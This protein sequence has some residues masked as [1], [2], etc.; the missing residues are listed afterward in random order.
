[1]GWGHADHWPEAARAVAEAARDREISWVAGQ[2]NGTTLDE[3]ELDA[4]QAGLGALPPTSSILP[5][6]GESLSSAMLRLLAAVFALERQQ[7]PA[8]PGLSDPL[9]QFAAQ[10]VREIRPA[11]VHRVLVASFGAGRRQLRHRRRA[12]LIFAPARSPAGRQATCNL[13]TRLLLI[14]PPPDS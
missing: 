7:L 9:R 2:G 1:M 10:L 14:R 5:L 8:T 11:A 4:L 3:R 12:G 6:S 13:C